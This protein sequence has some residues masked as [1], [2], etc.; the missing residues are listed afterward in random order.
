MA[1]I[2]SEC[3]FIL[4]FLSLFLIDLHAFHLFAIRPHVY[5]HV[6]RRTSR[7]DRRVH[8]ARAFRIFQ[9]AFRL[10]FRVYLI[11]RSFRAFFS[12]HYL[13]RAHSSSRR[14]E[15]TLWESPGCNDG[16]PDTTKTDILAGKFRR[17]RLEKPLAGWNKD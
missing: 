5:S 7:L 10:S 16:I 15:T 9:L 4:F 14:L 12:L 6:R 8:S 11:S 13:F 17:Y 3:I 2:S 1:R